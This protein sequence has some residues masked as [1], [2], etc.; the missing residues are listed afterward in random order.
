MYDHTGVIDMFKKT[1]LF[2]LANTLCFALL[3]QETN[4]NTNISTKSYKLISLLGEEMI[5][6]HGNDLITKIK[7]GDVNSIR[8]LIN[9]IGQTDL[10]FNDCFD[11]ANF[12]GSSDNKYAPN[13]EFG[14]EE[15]NDI[16]LNCDKILKNI[17]A[18][19]GIEN[20]V[21]EY[22]VK[23]SITANGVL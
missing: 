13:R 3:A 7:D 20:V 5:A 14:T 9:D 11:I 15:I 1:L 18:F 8:L 22:F 10:K 19:G 6:R 23:N 17:N 12:F 4:T 2:L 16:L 21:L